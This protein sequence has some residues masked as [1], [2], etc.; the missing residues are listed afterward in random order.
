[1][2]NDS[3]LKQYC[4]DGVIK[5]VRSRN[6]SVSGICQSSLLVSSLLKIL[7]P[8]SCCRCLIIFGKGMYLSLDTFVEGLQVHTNAN[9]T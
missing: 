5:V 6:D 9:S 3:L 2:P 7:A 8:V 1:M 4:P